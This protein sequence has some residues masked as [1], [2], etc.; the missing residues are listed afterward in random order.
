MEP[1]ETGEFVY[2][3]LSYA[4]FLKSKGILKLNKIP[5]PNQTEIEI[6]DKALAL[7][8]GK[9]IVINKD[10]MEEEVD[11]DNKI[12]RLNS[13][14]DNPDITVGNVSP[15]EGSLE[16]L[17]KHTID[18]EG[19][20]DEDTGDLYS[21]HIHKHPE[22]N[23]TYHWMK[24]LPSDIFL[25]PRLDVSKRKGPVKRLVSHPRA[26]SSQNSPYLHHG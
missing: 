2:T 20:G 15:F 23:Y 22:G 19:Q 12:I 14:H 16:D 25:M 17:R 7:S 1:I 4:D 18:L 11:L 8:L 13:L 5:K 26:C 21:V 6:K 10:L 24:P 3:D 9:Y